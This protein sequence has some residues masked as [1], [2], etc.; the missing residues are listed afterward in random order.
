MR[1][2]QGFLTYDPALDRYEIDYQQTLSILANEL[3]LELL[4][5]SRKYLKGRLLDLGCGHRPYALI[6]DSLV[7]MSIGTEIAFSP[8]GTHAADV[9]CFAENLP[10][11]DQQ[12]DTILCTEVLEHTT[13]PFQVMREIERLLK[14]GGHLI[15]SVPFIYPIHEP[16]H[17]HWRFTIYGISTICRNVGLEL[18]HT[19]TKG[20]LV[21]TILVL[22]HQ[23]AM[24]AL[25][26]VNHILQIDPP[27]FTY[28]EVRWLICQPQWWYLKVSRWLQQCLSS[29]TNNTGRSD[30]LHHFLPQ[31][32]TKDDLHQWMAL[33]Y[34]V[35]ARKPTH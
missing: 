12:F 11:P 27:L 3:L 21:T 24:R 28:S 29:I 23:I 33:G 13:H 5:K 7:D 30:R 32:A 2:Q 25:G 34:L 10:F 18:L 15:I 6:Y 8:H 22:G 14:P 19:Y 20:N 31:S 9:I 35:V 17:D 26:F 4:L 16:P 1:I